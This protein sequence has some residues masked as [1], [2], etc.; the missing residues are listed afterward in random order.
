[1]KP[2]KSIELPLPDDLAKPRRDWLDYTLI[3]LTGLFA[4]GGI[5]LA[6]IAVRELL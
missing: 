6:V 1:M 4:V 2:T 3:I 5:A